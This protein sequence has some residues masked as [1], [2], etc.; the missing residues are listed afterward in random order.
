MTGAGFEGVAG[1]RRVLRLL[2]SQL[3]AGHLAHAYLFTGEPELGKTAVAHRFAA[4]LLPE[5]PLSRHPDYWEDD[6]LGNLKVQEIRLFSDDGP[7]FHS[8]SLQAFLNLKPSTG[9]RRVAVISNIGRLPDVSQNLL[10]KTLEEPHPNRVIILTSPSLSPFVVIPT[11][12]SRCQRVNFHPVAEEEIAQLLVAEGVAADRADELA[13]LSRGRPG[14][15]RRAA[16]D[17]EVLDRHRLWV[18]RLEEVLGAP[19][20]VPLRLAAELDS[21]QLAWRSSD[22]EQ[23]DPFLE[24]LGSWQMEFRRRMLGDLHPATWARLLELSYDT[25]GYHE[26]NV[27]PRLNL[28]CLLLECRRAS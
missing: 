4:M 12:V 16:T 20:D 23:E 26:Q 17:P 13:R 25:L 14:W 10:L 2:E 7:E 11:I 18:Q 3:Q 19:A 28:E 22:K 6:R 15:A 5:V 24:A 1:H 9:E 27:S 21:Y 8:Q